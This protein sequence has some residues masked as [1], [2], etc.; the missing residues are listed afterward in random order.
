MQIEVGTV[1][2]LSRA[3]MIVGA[4][5]FA[6][7]TLAPTS[8]P[9][10]GFLAREDAAQFAAGFGM[11]ML[12]YVGFPRRRRT[13]LTKTV[14]LASAL[15]EILRY[16]IGHGCDPF[17]FAAGATG[18]LAVLATSGIE[19]FRSLTRAD[20]N[21]TFS[22]A[23]PN[24]RRKPRYVFKRAPKPAPGVPLAPPMPGADL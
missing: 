14:I 24:D 17:N 9:I 21:Q 5:A 1:N 11:T 6:Y 8:A 12:A 16:L 10:H 15:L 4:A 2:K 13:D 22:M 23:Y 18:S 20:P 3:A 7:W 19:R